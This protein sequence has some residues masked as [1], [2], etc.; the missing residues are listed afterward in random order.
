MDHNS[1]FQEIDYFKEILEDSDFLAKVIHEI[2]TPIHG[3]SGISSYLY[4]NWEN[5]SDDVKKSC[6]QELSNSGIFLEKLINRLLKLLE[7]DGSVIIYDMQLTDLVKIIENV[8][9]GSNILLANK[10]SI[11]I[12]VNCKS[13]DAMVFADHFW[14]GQ[15]FT[16][17]IINAI[18]HSNCRNI[19]IKIKKEK[20][21]SPNKEL[22]I[23]V[24][25]D[26]TGI[27]ETDLQIIFDSFKQGSE[28]KSSSENFGIGLS[29]CKEIIESHNGKIWAENKGTNGA[30]IAFTLSTVR[31]H[32]RV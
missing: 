32:D 15:V 27:P 1:K 16:N 20:S 3:I 28:I 14:I 23:S 24:I 7:T 25:D 10:N 6:I 13:K 17:L 2:K 4:E 18:K 26:G 5:V 30:I 29:L 12:K 11:N 19:E 21:L 22:L 9:K 31:K 8:I